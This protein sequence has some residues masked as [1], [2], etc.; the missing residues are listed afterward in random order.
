MNDY[1]R[2]YARYYDLLTGHKDYES[3][4]NLLA[5]FLERNF[6]SLD[7][8]VL[9]VGCGTGSHERLLATRVKEITGIDRSS[10]MIAYGR[11]KEAVANLKLIDA[12]LADLPDKDF[13]VVLSLFNVVNCIND[14][15]A[16][17]AFFASIASKIR[18]NGILIVEAWNLAATIRVPPQV[19]VR[20]Y[21]E[22]DITLTRVATP[23]LYPNDGI[24]RLEYHITGWD[25]A[26]PVSICSTHSIYLHSR[27]LIEYCLRRAGFGSADWYSALSEGMNPAVN[28][29]RML[30]LCAK[31]S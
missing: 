31:K 29:A 9:S 22:G 4:V 20:R 2:E 13:D 12:D 8:R 23:T 17:N 3:E 18:S 21:S 10:H 7:L 5:C 26:D 11:R 24:L 6:F 19:V 15:D 1:S 28:E 16:L 14:L 27:E 30:L 25:C